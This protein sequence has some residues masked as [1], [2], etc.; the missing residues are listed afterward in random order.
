MAN[1]NSDTENRN[2]TKLHCKTTAMQKNCNAQQ[3]LQRK[4]TA[5]QKAL[6]RER[7]FNTKNSSSKRSA[8]QKTATQTKQTYIARNSNVKQNATQKLQRKKNCT[9]KETATQQK[10]Q[11][12]R[13][14]PQKNCNAKNAIRT[15]CNAK[16]CN[17]NK[18]A[19]QKSA[20]QK[21]SATPPESQNRRPAVLKH[22]PPP[23][24]NLHQAT[25]PFPPGSPRNQ[26]NATKTAMPKNCN[27][28]KAA[29]QKTATR[30][31]AMQKSCNA[32][33]PATRQESQS[34]RSAVLKHQPPPDSNLHQT[35]PTLPPGSPSN[36]GN[37]KKICNAKK[38]AT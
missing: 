2:T 1:K 7:K 17:A 13:T 31:T 33:K 38:T 34:R 36:Q 35:T 18:T 9:V 21:E 37:A 20:M 14:A 12:K 26:D 24:P 6:Q 25:P 10:L 8:T 16:K 28:K 27:A 32:K 23:D 29:M 15:R 11:H 4:Q 19:T 22:Q 3:K 30:K 5:A